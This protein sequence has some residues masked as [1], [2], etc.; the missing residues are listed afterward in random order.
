MNR[1]DHIIADQNSAQGRVIVSESPDGLRTMRIGNPHAPR[2]S[3]GKADD[4]SHLELLYTRLTV[5]CLGWLD[6]APA[7]LLVIGLGGGSVPR[8][9]HAKFPRLRIDVVDI[10][11]V[12]AELASR[13]FNFRPNEFL[14]MEIVDASHWMR[15]HRAE[16][17]VIILDA[18][19]GNSMPE[20]LASESFIRLLKAGLKPGGLMVNHVWSRRVNPSYDRMVA[21]HGFVFGAVYIVTVP[22]LG[23]RLLVALPEGSCP[24][25]ET[26]LEQGKR[27]A[28][29]MGLETNALTA[30][31]H[32][33]WVS[34][35]EIDPRMVLR[36]GPE[37]EGILR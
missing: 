36:T 13:C 2:Q 33:R 14:R 34:A 1:S 28:V 27:W 18:F 15:C 10:D 21:T 6:Q 22:D 8:F 35:A 26:L 12:V 7:R 32:G 25:N 30:L 3:V 31:G 4:P 37:I 17:D 11:G 9:L 5:A 19:S 29:K 16:Y 24:T 20:S 23:G